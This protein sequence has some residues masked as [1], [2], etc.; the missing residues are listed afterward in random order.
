V[1]RAPRIDPTPTL[2][3]LETLELCGVQFAVR[4]P[5]GGHLSLDAAALVDF[6][7]DPVGVYCRHYRV[8]PEDYRRWRL[9]GPDLVCAF[10]HPVTL[11][12]CPI[13]LACGLN[14][15][16]WAARTGERC[17]LHPQD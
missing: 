17:R 15:G 6:L 14:P 12:R 10:R 9:E 3:F 5:A 16:E 11:G 4:L 1:T 7:V 2:Q 8:S 13:V